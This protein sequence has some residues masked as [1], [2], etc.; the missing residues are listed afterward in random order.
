MLFLCAIFNT[1]SCE[2][3]NNNQ[4]ICPKIHLI[5]FNINPLFG[6]KIEILYNIRS[7]KPFRGNN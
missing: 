5:L 3:L 6:I 4:F 1:N 7:T 2:I